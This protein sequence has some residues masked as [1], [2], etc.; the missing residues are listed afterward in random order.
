MHTPKRSVFFIIIHTGTMCACTH[1]EQF[2][3]STLYSTYLVG[4]RVI[5]IQYSMVDASYM[6]VYTSSFKSVSIADGGR[7]V[8]FQNIVGV[9]DGMVV[10]K[11]QHAQRQTDRQTDRERQTNT[12]CRI[13]KSRM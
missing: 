9:E 7:N 12:S 2:I 8:S 1:T 6:C 4:E 10:L 5:C 13:Q 3:C 11:L